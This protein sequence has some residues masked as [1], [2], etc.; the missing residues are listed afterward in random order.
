MEFKG[1]GGCLENSQKHL[2]AERRQ[3]LCFYTVFEYMSLQG[4]CYMGLYS[5]CVCKCVGYQ[6]RLVTG[7]PK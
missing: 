3:Q 7:Q 1:V 5:M 6:L 4:L 2:M